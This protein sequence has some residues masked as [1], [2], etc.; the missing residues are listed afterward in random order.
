MNSSYTGLEMRNNAVI[1]TQGTNT[2][3]G[4]PNLTANTWTVLTQHTYVVSSPSVNTTS[5]LFLQAGAATQPTLNFASGGSATYTSGVNMGINPTTGTSYTCNSGSAQRLGNSTGG[6]NKKTVQAIDSLVLYTT[7]ATED[8]NSY[9]VFP[10]EFVYQNKQMV[11][12][13][14]KQDSIN[15]GS[16]S[17]LD[18]FYVENQNT[19]INQLTEVREAIATNDV[20]N[21]ISKNSAVAASNS[22]EQK[23]Q[24][25][26]E[27][28]L[29][30]LSDR[31]YHFTAQEKL[32]LY[33]MANECLVKG[34][35]VAQSRNMFNVITGG[36]NT[37]LDNCETD[38]VASRKA[39]SIQGM[40]TNTSFLLF[41]NPNNGVMELSYDLGNDSEA[42]MK[43]FDVTGKLVSIY[44]L[45][46]NKGT[47]PINEHALHNG[48]YFYRILVDNK[49]IKTNK[50]VIIK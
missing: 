17:L 10:D 45:Q 5:K 18:S 7:L 47:M 37:Y 33:N 4:T 26:N 11:Y 23:H 29:K 44:K 49:V 15:A 3:T 34:Y 50:I 12:Q 19:V 13:L 36:M 22:V 48:V 38:A 14:L 9:E 46:N 32:D 1:G 21:A 31:F 40:V 39:K 16:G 28:V 20:H 42:M 35:Y 30:Y 25:A 27:L 2:Y 43:L 41:P 24:R 6:T 8:E